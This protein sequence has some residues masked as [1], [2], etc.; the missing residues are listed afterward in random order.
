VYGPDLVEGFVAAAL[1]ENSVGETYFLTNPENVSTAKLMNTFGEAVGKKFHITL[2]MPIFIMKIVAIFMEVFYHLN[3]KIANLTRDKVRDASQNWLCTPRKAKDQ[4]GWEAKHSLLEGGKITHQYML[5]QEKKAKAMACE[6]NAILFLKYFCI[7]ALIG[8][9]IEILAEF[10]KVYQFHPW[11]FM[12]GVIIGMWGILFGFIAMKTRKLH[13]IWQFIPGFL[14]LFGAELLNH[15][16]L[17]RWSFYPNDIF[18]LAK[19][20]PLW[21]AAWLGIA[22]GF[23]I[24]L[25][26]MIMGTLWEYKSRVG[27]IKG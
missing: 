3:R 22:T 13:F 4:L 20:T 7:G 8:V 9:I 2:P 1:N 26:N 18:G 10:G 25:Y 16:V 15:Y 27:A 12:F 5:E 17:H 24:P 11:Y 19:M 23:I 6:S 14:F 21:R